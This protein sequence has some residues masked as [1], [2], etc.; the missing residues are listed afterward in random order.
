[1]G[2]KLMGILRLL[3]VGLFLLVSI[4]PGATGTEVDKEYQLKAAYLFNFARFTSWPEETY[5]AEGGAFN[6]CV[7]GTNPFSSILAKIETKKI[8]DHPVKVHYFP[9]VDED[10]LHQC[11]LAFYNDDQT[12]RRMSALMNTLSNTVH[13]SDV[14]GFCLSG[15][16]IELFWQKNKLRFKIN[17]SAMKT[18]KIQPRASLLEMAAEVR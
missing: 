3:T 10:L 4:I 14:S 9:A 11:H 18:K 17:N 15:G 13:V 6:I 8:V 7:V 1:M 12:V 5:G 2:R 16:D